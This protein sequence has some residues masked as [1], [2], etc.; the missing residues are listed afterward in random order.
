M[1]YTAHADSGRSKHLRF[2]GCRAS[3]AQPSGRARQAPLGSLFQITFVVFLCGRKGFVPPAVSRS[4]CDISLTRSLSSSWTLSGMNE[5]FPTFL[6]YNL[7]SFLSISRFSALF[8]GGRGGGG[9]G[10]RHTTGGV[11][12]E[13]AVFD[14]QTM[15]RWLLAKSGSLALVSSGPLVC[16]GHIVCLFHGCCFAV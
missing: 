3:A 16:S 11:G 15:L 1:G 6:V 13:E 10:S 5:S 12:S 7:R 4:H 14:D 8:L 2:P 9:V